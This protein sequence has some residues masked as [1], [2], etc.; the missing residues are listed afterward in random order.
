MVCCAI[1]SESSDT[2]MFSIDML[3]V[4]KSFAELVVLF[5]LTLLLKAIGLFLKKTFETIEVPGMFFEGL[6][7]KL[8]PVLHPS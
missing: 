7:A 2:R 6:D 3:A 4:K 1:C 5:W 8:F